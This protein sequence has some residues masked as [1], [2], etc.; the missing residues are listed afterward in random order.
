[1]RPLRSIHPP[2]QLKSHL[3]HKVYLH[4]LHFTRHTQTSQL[5]RQTP[6]RTSEFDGRGVGLG[7]E[8]KCTQELP[9]DGTSAPREIIKVQ[10]Q[11]EVR[12]WRG[13][14]VDCGRRY[15]G[16]DFNFKMSPLVPR[17]FWRGPNRG[18]GVHMIAQERV[19][20][21][22]MEKRINVESCVKDIFQI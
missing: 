21:T 7:G 2:H 16:P 12:A 3:R 11:A 15:G 10:V 13:K 9:S 20:L 5:H 1:M 18:G 22:G 19:P 4:K 14:R 6:L 17:S 8:V